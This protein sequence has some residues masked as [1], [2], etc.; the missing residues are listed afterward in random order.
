MQFDPEA[1]V[2]HIAMVSAIGGGTFGME[3]ASPE[4]QGSFR[5]AGGAHGTVSIPLDSDER[6]FLKEIVVSASRRAVALAE[7]LRS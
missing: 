1:I 6:L 7:G 3:T 2:F 5:A 4:L